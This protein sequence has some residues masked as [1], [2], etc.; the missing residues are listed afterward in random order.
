[1]KMKTTEARKSRKGASFTIPTK[2]LNLK[3]ADRER[4]ASKSRTSSLT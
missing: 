2:L 3:R 1:M 4:N